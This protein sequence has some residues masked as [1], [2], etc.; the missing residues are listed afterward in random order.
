METETTTHGVELRSELL[1]GERVGFDVF[2]AAWNLAP[3]RVAESTGDVPIEVE[4]T[5]PIHSRRDV[6]RATTL[7][8]RLLGDPTWETLAASQ[9]FV[10]W[11]GRGDFEAI[12][13]VV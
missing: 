9:S 2:E 7:L 3:D 13:A 5:F 10:A 6:G 8:L 1:N 11:D 12:R 4:Q